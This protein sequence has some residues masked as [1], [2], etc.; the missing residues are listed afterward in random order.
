MCVVLFWMGGRCSV[1][2][3]TSLAT[4]GATAL[5]KRRLLGSIPRRFVIYG[6]MPRDIAS[7]PTKRS[8]TGESHSLRSIVGHKERRDDVLVH[9]E[10]HDATDNELGCQRR[11]LCCNAQPLVS[12]RELCAHR[13][14]KA[15][16]VQK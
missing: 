10:Q 16:A 2:T 3:H 15:A 11:L 6:G 12:S 9:E 8:D 14:A 4:L 7:R 5:Q 1:Y 13:H